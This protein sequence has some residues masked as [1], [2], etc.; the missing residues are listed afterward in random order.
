MGYDFNKVVQRR[1]T[2]TVKWDLAKEDVIPM[3]VADMDFEVAEPIVNA[4]EKR[5]KHPVYGYTNTDDSY[6]D[7]IKQWVKKRHG[8]EIEKEWIQYSP[9]VVPAVNMLI[10]AFTQP[11]DKV[12]LQVPVYH[13]FFKAVTNNGCEIVE[14]SLI[15]KD[16]KYKMDFEDLENKLS[17]SKVKVLV[18]CSPHNPVGRVWT[19]EELKRL[20]DLC[21][22]NNV[23]VISD[24]IHSD[25]IYKAYKH[26]PFGAIGKEFEENCAVC[27]APSKT[28]NLAG[29]QTSSVIIPNEK[30]RN[31]FAS[32]LEVN[33]IF[34]P[35]VF[36]IEASE[37]AYRYGEDWLDE[38]IDYL[39]GNLDFLIDYV[40]E[41]MP[42]VKTIRPEGTYLVWLDFSEICSD[43]ETLH[44]FLLNK[45]KV[46]FDEGYIFGKGGHGFERVNIACR[47]EV[48]EEGLRRIA[49]A[50]KEFNI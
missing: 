46:W 6:Y 13:P 17:D 41:N 45:G 2:K 40:E 48:L 50:L 32:V 24:E 36:G 21:I 16:G 44:N 38:L 7:S 42:K 27:I 8:W 37:A 18:L 49:D 22:K 30:L 28:F 33:G 12:I 1:G 35:N 39:Q 26:T 19:K 29:L 3:W 9:G 14:N 15:Y 11:G 25:L 4:I 5:A 10:R 34:G 23:I 43:A 31:K 20:G 47:R